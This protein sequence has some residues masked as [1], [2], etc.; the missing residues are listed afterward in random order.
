MN[1]L[2]RLVTAV[3]ASVAVAGFG[4]VS[5]APLGTAPTLHVDGKPMLIIGGELGNSRASSEPEIRECLEKAARQNLNTVLVPVYWDLIEPEEGMFDFSLPDAILNHARANGLKVVPLWFGAW[6]NSMSCYAPAWVKADWKRFPRAHT[7]AGRPLEILSAFSDEVFKADST[8]F[9]TLLSH[10]DSIDTDN[11][12]LMVQVENEIGMLEDARDHSATA[13][14]AFHAG[15]P[16]PLIAALG[17]QGLHPHMAGRIRLSGNNDWD[18]VFGG[19]SAEADECFMAWHYARYVGRLAAAARKVYGRPL[20][21]NAAMNSRGRR[22]GEYPSAGPLAH[23][24]DI[25]KA[26]APDVSLLAPDL[27]DKGFTSWASAYAMP[28]NPL[29]I[30]EIRRSG[31]NPAQ[32]LYAFGE[33]EAVG[34]SPFAIEDGSDNPDDRSVRGFRALR[35]WEPLLLK[36]RGRGVTRG[37][38]FDKDSVSG[39]IQFPEDGLSVKS[40]HFFTLPWDPRASDGSTWPA[41]GAVIARIA[42]MEYLVAGT[43]IVCVF[44]NEGELTDELTLGEDGFLA[45]GESRKEVRK[46]AGAE[47]VGILSCD[48]VNPDLCYVKRLSGDETHQG[49]HVRIS[50]DDFTILHVKL[51]RYR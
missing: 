27:Y 11:T 4:E 43:G 29:F 12:V 17:G 46:E 14:S 18:N 22:P 1:R 8:A 35:D 44:E 40:S 6:K 45:D 28:D 37:I 50:P 47:R 33:H 30:P 19:P 13:D 36:L 25:W 5:L 23:L 15:V 21:V 7:A 51:Y 31:D 38:Y 34:F 42:P 26:A 2:K 16:K 49:R 20:Y 41:G 48:V 32:A 9:I 10:L 24:K 3:C 39:R